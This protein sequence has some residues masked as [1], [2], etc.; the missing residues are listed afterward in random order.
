MSS[1]ARFVAEKRAFF[2]KQNLRVQLVQIPGGT[3]NMVKALDGGDVDLTQTATP[4]LIQAVLTGSD[5]I[6]IAGETANPIY[7]L[8]AR[9]AIATFADLKGRT[10]GLSLTVDTISIS[11]RKLIALKGLI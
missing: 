7:S 5:A 10:V 4:Y 2:A 1:L 11:T 8:I 6:A 3:V 9:P